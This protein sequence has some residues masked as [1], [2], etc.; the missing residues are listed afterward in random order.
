MALALDFMAL[1]AAE[2]AAQRKD[3]APTLAAARPAAAAAAE[4]SARVEAHPALCES[5]LRELA[6]GRGGDDA[7][8]PKEEEL[9]S[10]PMRTVVIRYEFLSA[11]CEADVLRCVLSPAYET[12]GRWVRLRGRRL[13]Q[14]GGTPRPGPRLRGQEPLP[15]WLS[16]VVDCLVAS[17]AVPESKRP[18]HVLVNAYGPGE[19]ILPHTDGPLYHPCTATLSLGSDAVMRFAP[20]VPTEVVGTP[21]QARLEATKGFEVGLAR[22]ALVVFSDE[23]YSSALHDVEAVCEHRITSRCINAAALGWEEGW[24]VPR[25]PLR[26]SLTMRHVP[27]V[28]DATESKPV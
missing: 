6:G 22:R 17:G 24:L 25:S 23:A 21:S 16:A 8:R 18:N 1:L 5:S 15:P 19:G 11:A 20:R 12:S 9:T 13:L 10:A 26:V 28:E 27:A 2:Q 4:A 3:R 7:T 14:F